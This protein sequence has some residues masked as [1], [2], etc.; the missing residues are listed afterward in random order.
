[1]RDQFDTN[2]QAINSYPNDQHFVISS[3]ETYTQ[4]DNTDNNLR[5]NK[6]RQVARPK[7]PHSQPER[8]ALSTRTEASTWSFREFYRDTTAILVSE[9]PQNLAYTRSQDLAPVSPAVRGGPFTLP[10]PPSPSNTIPPP[11]KPALNLLTPPIL[12]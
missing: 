8:L 5:R 6:P 2:T 3:L 11:L 7:L 12:F 4:T 9:G 10:Y 1:M